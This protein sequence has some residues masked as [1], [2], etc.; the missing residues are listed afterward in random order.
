[1]GPQPTPDASTTT[2]AQSS[3]PDVHHK[4][5]L[6]NLLVKYVDASCISGNVTALVLEL[7]SFPAFDEAKQRLLRHVRS[8]RSPII[9]F[10]R[11]AEK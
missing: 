10:Q 9:S 6:P 5:V 8:P 2:L 1:M 11:D 3:D 4:M 7:I